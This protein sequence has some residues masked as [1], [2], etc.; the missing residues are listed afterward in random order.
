MP[1]ADQAGHHASRVLGPEHQARPAAP[2]GDEAS[3]RG[4]H[5]ARHRAS[6]GVTHGARLAP[7]SSHGALQGPGASGADR[8]HPAARGAGEVDQVRGGLRD[9]EPLGQRCLARLQRGHPGVQGDRGQHHP[10]RDQPGHQVRGE[11]PGGARHLRAAGGV[12]EHRLV[13]GQRPPA[14]DVGVADRLAVPGQVAV[15]RAVARRHQGLPDP[16]GR[17]VRIGPEQRDRGASGQR[18]DLTGDPVTD[19]SW[20]GLT[21]PEF[22]QPGS[23]I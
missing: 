10:G 7:A 16:G 6:N 20:R 19:P 17:G 2:A 8:D 9:F 13:G 1:A 5:G 22:D 23:V 15:D 11:W 4:V 18:D 3:H 21:L 14:G 12:G